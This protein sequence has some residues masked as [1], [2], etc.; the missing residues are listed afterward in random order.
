MPSTARHSPGADAGTAT[1]PYPTAVG[2]AITYIPTEKQSIILCGEKLGSHKKRER[3]T[4]N[5]SPAGE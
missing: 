2:L 3:W 5:G 1:N 4:P